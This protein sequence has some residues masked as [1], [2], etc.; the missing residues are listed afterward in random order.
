[1]ANQQMPTLS[2]SAIA[3]MLEGYRHRDEVLLVPRGMRAKLEVA[4]QADAPTVTDN[5]IY[6]GY[7]TRTFCGVSVEVADIPREKVF[8]WSG[9]RS[10]ARARRRHK[11]GHPQRVTIIERDVAYLVGKLAAHEMAVAWERRC[12]KMIF[13]DAE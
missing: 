2:A 6:T 9:C 10:P 8:D 11:Q 7:S 1:M 5:P 4:C 12:V 13:G 3:K